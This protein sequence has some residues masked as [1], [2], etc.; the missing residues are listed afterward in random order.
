MTGQN[1][2]GEVETEGKSV[3]E[4][5]SGIHIP[6]TLSYINSLL[7]F[8]LQPQNGLQSFVLAPCLINL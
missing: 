6:R 8:R 1:V 2:A 4:D 7:A 3:D 5:A